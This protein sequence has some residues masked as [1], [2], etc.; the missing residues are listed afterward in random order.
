MPDDP[1]LHLSPPLALCMK[2]YL[3]EM[4][5]FINRKSPGEGGEKCGKSQPLAG[6]SVFYFAAHFADLL[7]RSSQETLHKEKQLES[8]QRSVPLPAAA[9]DKRLSQRRNV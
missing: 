5:V 6:V 4:E 3:T 7:A 9:K 2:C 8:A 1:H